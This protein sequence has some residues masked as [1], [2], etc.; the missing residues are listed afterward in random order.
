MS[1]RFKVGEYY[2]VYEQ[3]EDGYFIASCPSIKG[4]VAAG[5]T[6]DEAYQNIQEAIESCLEALEKVKG[7][8]PEEKFLHEQIAE[9]SFVRVGV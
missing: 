7:V 6:L 8:V 4:C 5:K 3:D 2:V 1:E 9:M